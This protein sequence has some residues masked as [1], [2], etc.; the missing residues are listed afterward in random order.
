MHGN[1]GCIARTGRGI[2]VDTVDGITADLPFL[3][4][5]YARLRAIHLLCQW[6]TINR[7]ICGVKVRVGFVVILAL[8]SIIILL[9][10][11]L[12]RT[13]IHRKDKSSYTSS[14]GQYQ[15]HDHNC[16]NHPQFPAPFFLHRL[17]I[18]C[19]RWRAIWRRIGLLGRPIRLSIGIGWLL[20][21]PIRLLPVWWLRWLI[22]IVIHGKLPSWHSALL[23]ST[24]YT[25]IRMS[26]LFFGVGYIYGK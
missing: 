3:C 1:R 9:R 8:N 18:I 19:W 13:I 25:V 5:T 26:A 14:T 24:H 12:R 16:Q 20:W 7:Y 15:H 4:I 2:Q 17:P 21:L 22:G 10:S 23:S 11:G 6:L